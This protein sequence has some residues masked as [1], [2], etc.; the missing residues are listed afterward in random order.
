VSNPERHIPRV[1]DLMTRDPMVVHP[2]DEAESLLTLFDEHD[3]NAFPV[4]DPEG[5]LRGVV[6]KSSLLR[7]FRSGGASATSAPTGPSALRVRDVMDTRNVSVEPTD[8][9]DAIVRQMT[10]YHVRSVPVVE[11]SGSRRRLV[12][13]VS[14]G[15]FL[16]GLAQAT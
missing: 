15:D 4:I 11:R 5:N 10:R 9:V 16:R 14:R 2:E 8:N 13:M 3:F 12:G 1:R 7:L 6:T